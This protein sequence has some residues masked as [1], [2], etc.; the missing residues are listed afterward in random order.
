MPRADE[1]P[2][3]CGGTH[4]T[5]AGISR[6]YG[7]QVNRIVCLNGRQVNRIVSLNG[8][9]MESFVPLNII[10]FANMVRKEND[11]IS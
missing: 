11:R 8:D 2:L 9:F 6:Q 4:P 3:Q 1:R 10:N 7:P 5:D